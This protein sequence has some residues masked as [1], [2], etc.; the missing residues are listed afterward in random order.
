MMKC[1]K[2]KKELFGESIKRKGGLGT[3][4]ATACIMFGGPFTMAV[5]A[6]HLGV[7]A[8]EKHV[9][10]EVEIKCPHCKAKLTLTKDEFKELKA[11]MNRLQEQERKAKQ[12]RIIKK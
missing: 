9:M 7:R 4:A 10:N 5:G 8:F 1:P 3:V 11:E 2:C 6:L 12:N